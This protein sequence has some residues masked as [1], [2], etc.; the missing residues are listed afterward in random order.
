M[1]LSTKARL[2]KS[3]G[4]SMIDVMVAVLI[5]GLTIP[6]I[7][8]FLHWNMKHAVKSREQVRASRLAQMIT[9]RTRAMSF[10]NVFTK[11]W[12]TTEF[13]DS[14]KTGFG[15]SGIGTEFGDITAPS[16]TYPDMAHLQ[17][18]QDQIKTAGFSHF[19]IDVQHMR[20]DKTNNVTAGYDLVDVEIDP[21][22]KEDV[23]DD[24]VKYEDFNA[25]GDYFDYKIEDDK[26]IS[27]QPD[28]R[29]KQLTVRIYKG[30]ETMAMVTGELLTAEMFRGIQGAS[31][32]SC[33]PL[34]LD[35]DKEDYIHARN[36]P[37]QD[38]AYNTTVITHSSNYDSGPAV[39]QADSGQDLLLTGRTAPTADVHLYWT[40]GGSSLHSITSDVNGDFTGLSNPLTTGLQEGKNTFYARTIK[41]GLRSPYVIRE[42]IIYDINPPKVTG[43][44]P[45]HGSKVKTFSPFIGAKLTDEPVTAGRD[46]SGLRYDVLYMEEKNHYGE[47][48]QPTI[49]PDGYVVW[50]DT[51]TLLPIKLKDD[52]DYRIVLEGGDMAHYK[53]SHEWE[54]EIDEIEDDNEKPE[55][56]DEAPTGTASSNM[57]TISFKVTDNGDSGVK[58]SSIKVYLDFVDP[59]NLLLG[60]DV[61]AVDSLG[62][63]YDGR[64]GTV[65]FDMTTP[66]TTGGHTIHVEVKD[67][68]NNTTDFNWSFTSP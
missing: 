39:H 68:K 2:S 13:V 45:A 5:L 23:A 62:R 65:S 7:N 66:L 1:I 46:V 30:P 41:G 6:A 18:I 63:A 20:R 67:W 48:E 40:K 4:F 49:L 57:P 28:T 38:K 32:E 17:D 55:I 56:N 61:P 14:S 58:P 44:Y 59:A 11:D 9:A 19:T 24:Q 29:V 42:D 25:D 31:S 3:H 51:T 26:I 8:I 36:E 60:E 43:V 47:I 22:T 53:V 15:L 16:S 21:A 10:F 27:E 33:L 34:D 12:N 54:F 64:D 37:E 35:L 52:R 50:L